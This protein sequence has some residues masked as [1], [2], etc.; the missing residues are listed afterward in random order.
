MSFKKLIILTIICLAVFYYFSEEKDFFTAILDKINVRDNNASVME[1][2]DKTIR[3]YNGHPSGDPLPLKEETKLL[4][5]QDGLVYKSIEPVII[6]GMKNG[7][8]GYADVKVETLKKE[9]TEI[10]KESVITIPGLSSTNYFETT[11]AELI[12][13]ENEQ[14]SEIIGDNEN[15]ESKT[16]IGG[17]I[18][19]DTIWELKNSPYIINGNIFIPENVTLLI[20]S[21][22]EVIF[23]ED[24]GFLIEGEIK[25]I[26]KKKEPIKLFN[27]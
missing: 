22:V 13:N 27:N 24:Y 1:K 12:D 10:N 15:K 3:I 16:L 8:P 4:S 25:M 18:E 26:G 5:K 2:I 21:G 9:S 6:P 19:K 20:E 23:N 17:I 14:N 11:W 7:S